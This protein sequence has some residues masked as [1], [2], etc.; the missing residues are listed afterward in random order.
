MNTLL[1]NLSGSARGEI[2]RN[3]LRSTTESAPSGVST[4]PSQQT[5]EQVFDDKGI[6]KQPLSRSL[7]EVKAGASQKLE[8]KAANKEDGSGPNDADELD[9][10]SLTESG[11]EDVIP[12]SEAPADQP[13]NLVAPRRAPDGVKTMA[14]GEAGL[15]KTFHAG[16]EKSAESVVNFALTQ[17]MEPRIESEQR[18]TKSLA[19]QPPNHISKVAI[20]TIGDSDRTSLPGLKRQD[21]SLN[22][23]VFLQETQKATGMMTLNDQAQRSEDVLS[24]GGKVISAVE[25]L[26]VQHAANPQISGSEKQQNE[27]PNIPA[28]S[29]HLTMNVEVQDQ[30][31]TMRASVSPQSIRDSSETTK[32]NMAATEPQ[33]ADPLVSFNK[34]A[35]VPGNIGVSAQAGLAMPQSRSDGSSQ[36][37]GHIVKGIGPKSNAATSSPDALNAPLGEHRTTAPQRLG[38]QH[39]QLPPHNFAGNGHLDDKKNDVPATSGATGAFARSKASASTHVSRTRSAMPTQSLWSSPSEHVLTISAGPKARMDEPLEGAPVSKG[40]RPSPLQQSNRIG[41]VFAPPSASTDNPQKLDNI[42]QSPDFPGDIDGESIALAR[43]DTL[44][45][46]TVTLPPPA[47]RADLPQQIARQIAEAFQS[48]SNRPVDITLNPEELGRVRLALTST[49][50]GMVMQVTAERPETLELLRRHIS[51]LGQEFQDIGYSDISFNFTGEG[52]HQAGQND[53]EKTGKTD[54]HLDQAVENKI[55]ISLST[56][57]TT[58]LDIRL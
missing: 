22:H 13:S 36:T 10:D 50:T 31:A 9:F 16:S 38:S 55:A 44:T 43:T 47:Q 17:T 7:D 34:V 30:A 41:A 49:D 48:G 56:S 6:E 52:T 27:L 33:R 3:T 20:G 45:V 18:E 19:G 39:A 21:P 8:S 24:E 1:P 28:K 42:V 46:S 58:G 53:A 25:K 37:N 54:E 14:L 12:P 32:P 26:E 15:G 29:P 57:P 11:D 35:T 23:G 5:F 40:V 2:D 4:A 51:E